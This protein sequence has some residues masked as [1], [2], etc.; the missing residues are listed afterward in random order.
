[1]TPARRGWRTGRAGMYATAG[2]VVYANSRR[3]LARKATIMKTAA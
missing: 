3:L 2:A 1:M